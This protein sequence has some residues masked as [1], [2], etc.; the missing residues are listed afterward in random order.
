VRL[1]SV[2]EDAGRTFV[3][4]LMPHLT[5][6]WAR[7][8]VDDLIEA[9]AASITL[10]DSEHTPAVT[11][12]VDQARAR[13]AEDVRRRQAAHGSLPALVEEYIALL[14]VTEDVVFASPADVTERP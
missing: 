8:I 11:R 6:E 12:L 5:T 14:A 1:S 10:L 7:L 9:V 2:S 4:T 3:E 13:L